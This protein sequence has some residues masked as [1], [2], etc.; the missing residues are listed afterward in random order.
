M[1]AEKSLVQYGMSALSSMAGEQQCAV[2]EVHYLRVS[3]YP[4]QKSG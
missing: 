1:H 3:V 4:D 2:D